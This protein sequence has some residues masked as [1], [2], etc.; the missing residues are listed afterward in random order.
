MRLK[1]Y[2]NLA[3]CEDEVDKKHD[4]LAIF[5]KGTEKV[6][7]SGIFEEIILFKEYYS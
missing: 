4:N 2:E 5:D 3:N 1:K 6:W 7:K